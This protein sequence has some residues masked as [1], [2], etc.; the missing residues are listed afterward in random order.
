MRMRL[1]SACE[2]IASH[3]P[4]WLRWI[5][6]TRFGKNAILSTPVWLVMYGLF[7]VEISH[8]DMNS[9][10]AKLLWSPLGAPLGLMIQWVV[11]A[12]RL[13]TLRL[14]MSF[15]RLAGRLSWRFIATKGV[16][17]LVNQ[18][19]Y[20]ALLIKAGLPPLAA[21]PVSAATVSIIYYFTALLWITA[22]SQRPKTMA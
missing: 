20:G 2:R 18:L 21:A 15:K 7:Y 3:L 10:Q 9:Q 19:A 11:F 22:D 5:W 12:D 1:R 6:S 13:K 17:F 8:L 16:F 14:K 4:E